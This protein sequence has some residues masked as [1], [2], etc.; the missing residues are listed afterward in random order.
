MDY[1]YDKNLKVESYEFGKEFTLVTLDEFQEFFYADEEIQNGFITKQLF[2]SKPDFTDLVIEVPFT[3]QFDAAGMVDQVH[4]ELNF[5]ADNNNVGWSRLVI[6][7][8][9]LRRKLSLLKKR[10][11]TVREQLEAS[12][13]QLLQFSGTRTA[14][15]V[16]QIGAGFI[17]A[18]KQALDEWV[19]VGHPAIIQEVTAS[20]D[21][22]L[23][24][25]PLPLG[26]ASIRQYMIGALSA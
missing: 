3:Y 7:K 12:I 1:N 2:Y 18:H 4:K 6:D 19:D 11:K 10:R 5:I 16:L 20:T 21:S 24:E 26:G 25:T 8:L 13:L 14:Q 9:P 23:D 15:E 22:W 17:V